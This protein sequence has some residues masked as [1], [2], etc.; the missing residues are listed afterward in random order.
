MRKLRG[1]VCVCGTRATIVY[2][3][4]RTW[5]ARMQIHTQPTPGDS[6]LSSQLFH[7]SAQCKRMC[8][9]RTVL[10]AGGTRARLQFSPVRPDSPSARRRYPSQA[11]HRRKAICSR[12]KGARASPW[13]LLANRRLQP[14]AMTASSVPPASPSPPSSSFRGL[15]QLSSSPEIR[16]PSCFFPR[17][18]NGQVREREKQTC[19]RNGS[20]SCVHV[21]RQKR[22]RMVV[23]AVAKRRRRARFGG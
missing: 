16:N 4:P 2:A 17:E 20:V 6:F 18:K 15:T 13:T 23:N 14:L 8:K 19:I 9:Q 5:E 1:I 10:P 3:V 22:R 11:R 12:R 7:I 21:T